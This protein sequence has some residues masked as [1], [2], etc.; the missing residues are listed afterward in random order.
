[1]TPASRNSTF[2]PSS[3]CSAG[4]APVCI[5]VIAAAVSLGY[6]DV[7]RDARPAAPR[8][9]SSGTDSRRAR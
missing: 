7:S 8:V 4:V 3:P 9:S 1:M 2:H 6:T 5:V